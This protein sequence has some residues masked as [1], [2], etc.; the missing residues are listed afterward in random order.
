MANAFA[1]KG[2]PETPATTVKLALPVIVVRNVT[3]IIGAATVLNASVANT[4]PAIMV[5]T[6]MV[7]ALVNTVGLVTPAQ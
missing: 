5:L 2:G 6:A 3:K 1:I 7:N 4:A